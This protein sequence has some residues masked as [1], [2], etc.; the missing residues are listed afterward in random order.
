MHEKRD[1]FKLI[2]VNDWTVVMPKT[3]GRDPQWW[4]WGQGLVA[5][6]V[7][8]FGEGRG[9][10]YLAREMCI[11]RK[12]NSIAT[13]EK[14]HHTHHF[15]SP[16]HNIGT[17]V[18][19]LRSDDSVQMRTA[20]QRVDMTCRSIKR[21]PRFHI[22]RSWMHAFELLE[23]RPEQCRVGRTRYDDAPQQMWIHMTP[24]VDGDSPNDPNSGRKR[25]G[26]PTGHSQIISFN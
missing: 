6:G 22:G 18:G 10:Q 26:D 25:T 21:P 2:K 1:N 17:L 14:S 12:P 9:A 8:N 7:I 4:W 15:F 11:P 5:G 3:L 19:N 20:R 13:I 16:F 23:Y 24:W